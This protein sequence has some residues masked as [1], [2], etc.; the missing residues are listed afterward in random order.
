MTE[1]QK[2]KIIELYPTHSA[3]EIGKIIGLNKSRV[4]FFAS[5]QGIKH[6]ERTLERLK[7][8]RTAK[9]IAAR[10]KDSWK[11]A[12]DKRRRTYKMEMLRLLSGQKKQTKIIV[13]VLPFKCR[14]RMTMLC[15]TFNYFRDEDIN[16]AVVYYDKETRRSARAE[17]YAK[18]KYGIDFVEADE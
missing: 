2:Q 18:E 9:S 12:A 11:K 1:E 13:S 4:N 3:S 5:K 15:N 14:R 7:H 6:T 10:N 17:K 16:K 8:E